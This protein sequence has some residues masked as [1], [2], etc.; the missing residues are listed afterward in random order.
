MKLAVWADAQHARLLTQQINNSE[1][2]QFVDSRQG[3]QPRITP[4]RTVRELPRVVAAGSDQAVQRSNVTSAF[5]VPG[6]DD[7]R[8]AL[9]TGVA[10]GSEF[11]AVLIAH[12]GNFG[13]LSEDVVALR[14]AFARGTRV[15]TLL[16]LPPSMSD[17]LHTWTERSADVLS[18]VRTLGLPA[19]HPAFVASAELLAAFG[20][21]RSA[22]ITVHGVLGA[23]GLGA[24]LV[25][26]CDM[27]YSLVGGN[28]DSV[29]RVYASRSQF[30]QHTGGIKR[31]GGAIGALTDPHLNGD[32]LV[33]VTLEDGRNITL[34]VSNQAAGPWFSVEAV[35]AQGKA[36]ITPAGFVWLAPDGS[37]RTHTRYSP[38]TLSQWVMTDIQN[39]FD[40]RLPDPGPL[41]LERSLLTAHAALLSTT[42]L[43]P[44]SPATMRRLAEQV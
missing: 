33:V 29:A 2:D 13:A 28:E 41:A 36:T 12:S 18:K 40:V 31:D 38:P 3:S 20:E 24:L 4:E 44:E 42:T 8:S 6:F 16:P 5:N 9:T 21:L 19:R 23:P 11:D 15:F 43:A 26:A 25:S 35:G 10:A 34:N 37:L 14:T 27:L 39:A 7:L 30:G 32:V 1:H 22:C 17:M